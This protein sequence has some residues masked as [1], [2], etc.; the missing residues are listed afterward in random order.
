M[1]IFEKELDF[2]HLKFENDLQGMMEN[3][4]TFLE[5]SKYERRM[6][7]IMKREGTDLVDKIES[8]IIE[9]IQKIKRL[10]INVREKIRH[11]VGEEC[12]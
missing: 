9:L 11:A 12:R 2:I 10:Y 3:D 1:D 4:S 8:F 6:N 5:S 7:R